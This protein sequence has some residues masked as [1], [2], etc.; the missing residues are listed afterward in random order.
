MSG[1]V[2]FLSTHALSSLSVHAIF[3][4]RYNFQLSCLLTVTAPPYIFF[5]Y[6]SVKRS[7]IIK[8]KKGTC[9][10]WSFLIKK[11]TASSDI[12][13][14]AV[15]STVRSNRIVLYIFKSVNRNPWEIFIYIQYIEACASWVMM[16][17]F[18]FVYLF[19]K[20]LLVEACGFE[21]GMIFLYKIL[22]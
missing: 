3:L 7:S 13:N 9:T 2:H 6:C 8:T 16:S 4:P 20:Y 14:H 11:N 22:W 21:I 5:G 18:C 15:L 10:C 19:L 17:Y 12:K 1:K